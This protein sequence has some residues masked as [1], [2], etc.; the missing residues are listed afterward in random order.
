M[1]SRPPTPNDER[2]SAAG[3]PGEEH[4]VVRLHDAILREMAEPRDGHEPPPLLLVFGM[5]VLL[6]WGGWY[7]GTYD[8]GFRADVYNEKPAAAGAVETPSVALA[9]DPLIL[10]KRVFANCQACHQ[11]DGRGVP[12]NFPPLAGSE[13]VSGRADT[14]VRLV[15]HGAQGPLSVL[16]TSYNQVMPAWKHLTDEQL[17]AVLTF[18]RGSWGNQ[19]EG[20]S[21]ALVAEVRAAEHGRTQ[22]WTAAELR[23]AESRRIVASEAPSGAGA[24]PTA[25]P[26]R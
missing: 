15:L 23:A 3:T 17:A 21:P 7:L 11:T 6:G 24:T 13:W 2:Q 16:G 12:G 18:V 26:G 5:M 14:L 9:I 1:S 25:R 19:A 10:G 4:G 22:P 20:V 8:G